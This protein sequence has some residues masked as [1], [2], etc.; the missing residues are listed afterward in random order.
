MSLPP[1]NG[2]GESAT[3]D[4]HSVAA[5]A[6][7]EIA[8]ATGLDGLEAVRALY[9]GRGDGLLT[10]FRKQLGAVVDPQARRQLGQTV[11]ELCERT[12]KALEE[13][14]AALEAAVRTRQLEIE[15]LD[16][17]RPAPRLCRGS[18]HPVTKILREVRRIFAQLGYSAASGPE[19]EY[20]RYN[21]TLVNMPPGHPSRETQATFF[22]DEWRVL[23]TQTS[24]V[25]IRSMI[26]H[27]APQRIIAPGKTF[28]R[29]YDATHF[30]MFH[31]I[32]GLCIDEGVSLGD[33]KGTL[34]YF[35]RSLFG[36]DRGI[37]FR[38]HHFE[39]TEP[40]LEV[41][42]SC[43][44]CGGDGCKTCKHSGWLE[45]LGAGMVHPIVLRNG[46]IDPEIYSGF[47]F[48]VGAERLAQLLYVIED[49]RLVYENDVRY[50]RQG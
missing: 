34:E 7:D 15:A 42:I 22:I 38:P 37:R 43:M 48:G 40:S 14:R 23:R 39:F 32:E 49:G 1:G 17:T 35:A 16:L 29:D 45:V 11:N 5:H 47:A 20:D 3:A 36:P 26:Q 13:R 41:D 28:R 6:L 21:F 50:L 27:G 25:Q 4:M 24:P 18:L 9:L 12:A 33:L 10:I 31:Q 44:V 2:A 46:G 30:P 19:I 8:G